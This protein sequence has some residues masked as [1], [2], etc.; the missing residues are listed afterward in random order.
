MAIAYMVV[1]FSLPEPENNQSTVIVMTVF[2]LSSQPFYAILLINLIRK[3]CCKKKIVQ[4]EKS[5]EFDT[6]TEDSIGNASENL[7]ESC[8]RQ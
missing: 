2:Y 3:K 8:E 7:T 1:L 5:S 4:I 6:I